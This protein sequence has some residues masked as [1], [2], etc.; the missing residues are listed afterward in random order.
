[1]NE[2]ERLVGL[3]RMQP[4]PE[5][6][7]FKETYRSAGEIPASALPDTY[8][9]PRAYSTAILYLLAGGRYSAFH[10]LK[11]DEMWHFYAGTGLE[12]Y[13]LQE[14]QPLRTIRMGQDPAGGTVFQALAPAGSWF[15]ACVLDPD[16]YALV[17]CTVAPGFDYAD[18]ELAR[19]EDLI[20]RFPGEAELITRLTRT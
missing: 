13:L 20:R 17:G 14:G 9:G 16:G 7:F 10:R 4:H 11:S 12:L 15:A 8:G 3:Y 6:G 5:G 1:M 18:F 2:V 19:R